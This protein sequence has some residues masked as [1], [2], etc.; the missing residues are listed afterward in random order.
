MNYTMSK[1]QKKKKKKKVS[2]KNITLSPAR[3]EFI[4]NYELKQELVEKAKT[5]KRSPAE[6]FFD[7]H[8]HK[9]EFMR[10]FFALLTHG[11]QG[12]ILAKLFGAF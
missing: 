3:E 11:L 12:V 1:D 10:T 6:R 4:A 2:N 7:R 9:M 5:E 8:N